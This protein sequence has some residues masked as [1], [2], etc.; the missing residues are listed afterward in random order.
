MSDSL[1]KKAVK[2]VGWSFVDN[3]SNQGVTFLVGLVL[4]RILTPSEFGI[5]GMI[6][7]FIAISNSIVDSGFSNA[8]IR[9]QDA[10]RI[11]YNTV[12]LF[13][14]AVS[15]LFYFILY[16]SAPYIAQFFKEPQLVAITRV[17]G[18]VLI[19]NAFGIIQ[20]TL[21]NKR[22]DFKTQTKVSIISS[23]G[24]GVIGIGMAIKGL[25]AW[26]LVGQQISRQFLNTLFLWVFNSWRP[27]LEF[28]KQSF[29]ELFGFGSKLMLSGIIN[30][31]FKNIYYLVI[32]KY[33]TSY[34]L[35]QY[36]RAEQFRSIFAANLT[37]IVQKVS[38]PLLSTIQ[39]ESERLKTGYRKIVKISMLITFFCMVSMA[40]IAKPMIIILIGDKWLL[41]SEYLQI[42]CFSALLYPMHAL[43]L[44]IL[45]VKGRS[46]LFL[47]LE[48][49]KNLLG[50]IPILLG[51]LF[52][53]KIMLYS[54]ILFS[55]IHFF[56]NSFYS[57]RMINYS[58]WEQLKD[59]LPTF[60]LSL[61]IGLIVWAI[62]LLQ[63]NIYMTLVLQVSVG[64]ILSIFML[65]M[66]KL[67]EYTEVKQL[68]LSVLKK[69]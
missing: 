23:V 65:E 20:R 30:T 2:G 41:A 61:F 35:G 19:I 33:Y 4:A 24:S 29:K 5:L 22:I 13:N 51:I 16:I 18:L 1:K 14:I 34:D 63:I 64:I 46:D 17:M 32:G 9:K 52:S 48:I 31:I 43:N 60:V 15:L 21:L 40:A 62:T 55:I 25:G 57:K 59:I 54:R 8:L 7:I 50:L 11:D 45:Q 27:I 38:Y 53:I 56:M 28:S 49:P 26:S 47:K 58:S 36:T 67:E 6:T 44:N 68:I 66:S 10:K 42:M 69:K 12:F 3:I 37:S 39:N